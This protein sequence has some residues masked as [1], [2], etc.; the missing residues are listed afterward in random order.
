MKIAI[1]NFSGNVGKTVIAKHLLAPKLNARRVTIESINAGGEGADAEIKG[2]Q[3]KDLALELTIA[4]DDEHFVIDIGSSN[5]EL[6]IQQLRGMDGASGDFDH[7]VLPVT[8]DA[9]QQLD[10]INTVRA[11]VALGVEVSDISVVLNRVSDVNTV[12]NDYA[13]VIEGSK[14]GMYRLVDVPVLESDVYDRIKDTD[15]SIPD[16]AADKTDYQ[17]RAR[18]ETDRTRRLALGNQVITQRM[19][20][21]AAANLEA[22][23]LA[24]AFEV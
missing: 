19:S 9:K 24:L 17:A 6:V 3:Y 5:I 7:F 11:L 22:V 15:K 21:S 4:G 14:T 23:W 16:L 1:V 2:S 13:A 20:R 18:A 12:E 10:T 8:P